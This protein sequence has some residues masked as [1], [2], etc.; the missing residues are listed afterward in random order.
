MK[1]FISLLLVASVIT[2]SMPLTAKDRKGAD[3]II[4]K[5]DGT[6]VSGELIAV[7]E[8]SLLLKERESGAD[9]TV[10]VVD[11]EIITILKKSN[12]LKSAG[13][14]LLIGGGIGVILGILGASSMETIFRVVE[15][16]QG[17]KAK[18]ALYAGAIGASYGIVIGLIVGAFS[19]KEKTFQF[20]GKTDSEMREILEKLRKKARVKNV[21]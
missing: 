3:L 2:L 13:S 17:E 20:E 11:V 4:Q 10:G 5:S 6:Q 18:A 16:E 7:K 21:R 14:G 8:R 9:V 19:G 15:I 1:R 12:L